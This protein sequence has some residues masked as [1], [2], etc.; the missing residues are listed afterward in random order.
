MPK[1]SPIT[2][3]LLPYMAWSSNFSFLLLLASMMQAPAPRHTDLHTIV[4][5]KLPT[6][7]KYEFF[8]A[9]SFY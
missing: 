8:S 7:F 9:Q 1:S 5:K 4:Y 6:Q 2:K 3:V